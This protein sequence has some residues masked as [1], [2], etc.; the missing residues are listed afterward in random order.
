LAEVSVLT[1]TYPDDGTADIAESF[2]DPRIVVLREPHRGVAHLGSA[3]ARALATSN[4]PFVAV[5]EGDDTWPSTKLQDQLPLFNDP[6]V[7]LAYGAAGLMDET[8][9]VYARHWHAPRGAVGRNN[10]V[11]TILPALVD[12][13]FVVAATVMVRRRALDQIGGFFQPD[14]IPYVDHPTWLRLATVG[15][16]ARSSRVL[17]CWR[18][19]AHQITTQRWFDKD[20]DR[21]EYLEMVVDAAR[22]LVS[23]R[24][25]AALEA[26][27]RRD[28][29]RQR[30]EALIAQ[31][32]V[33]LLDGSWRQAAAIFLVLLREGEL[34]TRLV[35]TVGLLCAGAKADMERLLGVMGRHSLPSRRQLA[36]HGDLIRLKDSSQCG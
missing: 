12:V 1:P 9:R 34:R 16:F 27:C 6:D 17:G 2:Q 3:Y 26:S 20:L 28:P 21:T 15:K 33:A 11:G 18:R 10:P 25:F 4:S 14:G 36:S 30:E 32:R 22:P 29:S 13:N 8:G 24:K 7:V 23:A 31:G 5:L 35:A 19:H